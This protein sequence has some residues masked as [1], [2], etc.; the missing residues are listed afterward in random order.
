[1]HENI[2][3]KGAREHNLKNIDLTI[4]RNKL[5]VFTGLSG[6]GKSSLA[7][8]TI[9]AEGRDATPN[10]SLIRKAISR[11]AGKAGCRLNR[12]AFARNLNRPEDDA[13]KPA[14]DSRHRHGDLRLPAPLWAR[15]GRPH[16]PNQEA[17][18]AADNRPDY[19]RCYGAA[20]GHENSGALQSSGR[21][22]ANTQRH[23]RTH[24]QRLCQGAR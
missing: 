6:S 23:S 15:V 9:Y 7:F 17:D 1:M 3:I 24:T 21:G 12:G 22:R 11:P 13:Q 8:D 10:P 14:L 18:N 19:R 5:I 16:C 20:G 2:I 4:P